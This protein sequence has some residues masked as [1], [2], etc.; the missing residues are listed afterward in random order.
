LIVWDK[1][2][3]FVDGP[4]YSI[5]HNITDVPDVNRNRLMSRALEH[6]DL[7]ELYLET[8]LEAGRVASEVPAGAPPG[9]TRGWLEREIERG[10]TLIAPSVLS[11]TLKP[12]TNAEF[13]AS[14]EALRFFARERTRLVNTEVAGSR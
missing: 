5:W 4:A 6:A 14:V 3:A 13:E 2:Q 10:Y 1:S 9:D 12:Y 7:R 8:L 11:D